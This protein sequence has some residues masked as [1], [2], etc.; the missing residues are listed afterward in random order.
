M[1]YLINII[2]L[3]LLDLISA[4]NLTIYES[5]LIYTLDYVILMTFVK[6]TQKVIKLF[7][8]FEEFNRVINDIRI[9]ISELQKRK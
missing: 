3:N 5:G 4:N 9:T 7:H 2:S 8:V 1:Y 6:I